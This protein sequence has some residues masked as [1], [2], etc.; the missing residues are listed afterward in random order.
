MGKIIT[1]AS[2]KHFVILLLSGLAFIGKGSAQ[3]PIRKIDTTLKIGK[4]G[5]RVDCRNS[6]IQQNQLSI[7]PVGFQ[8]EARELSFYIRGFVVKEEIDDLNNDGF[9]DLLLYIYMDSTQTFGTV[10]AFL[11][12]ANKS[13]VSCLLPDPMLDGKI[14]QG[15][16]GHDQFS[17]ME[18]YLLEKFP[19]YKPGDDKDKPTGGNRVLLYQLVRNTDGGFKFNRVRLYETQ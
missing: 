7:R 2:M 19:I 9:P 5:Y 4:T 14:N 16:K 15:Y 12:D 1:F 10:Y 18:G 11:S 13:I 6:N 8:S 3:Y 17:R